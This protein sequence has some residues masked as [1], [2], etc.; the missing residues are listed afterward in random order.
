[1][2]AA[3]IGLFPYGTTRGRR[4]NQ[5]RATIARLMAKR[6]ERAATVRGSD[7]GDARPVEDQQQAPSRRNRG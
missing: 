1:M 3:G 7:V 4:K 2:S 5:R 6:R